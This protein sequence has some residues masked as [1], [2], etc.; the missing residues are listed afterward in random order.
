MKNWYYFLVLLFFSSFALHG[1]NVY[2]H[3]SELKGMED[4]NGNTN[5]LYRINSIQKNTNSEIDSNSIYLFNTTNKTDSLFQLDYGWSD[6]FFDG[7][8]RNVIGF[9]FW[10][11]DPRK[12]IVCGVDG[13]SEPNPIVDRFDKMNLFKLG[14]G[15]INFIGISRQNDSLVYCTFWNN[16]LFKS[17]TG[18]MTWNTV[19]NFNAISLSP[20]NDKILFTSGGNKLIKT[21]DGGL[22]QSIVDSIPLDIYRQDQLF[23]DKDTNYIYSA[24]TYYLDHRVYKLLVSHNSGNAPWQEKFTSTLP[25][26]LSVDNSTAGSVYLATGKN[27]YQ[28]TDFGNTFNLF[29]SFDRK[30]VGI[31]K[32]PESSKL[33]AATYNTIYEIDGATVNI[34]KQIP[35]D[36]E[37]FKFDPLDIGNKWVYKGS[38]WVPEEQHN[39]VQSAE[40]I[41]DTVMENQQIFKQIRT[42]GCDA[43]SGNFVLVFHMK[44][45]IR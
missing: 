31:Y 9:D 17:T 34:I 44:E 12:F 16:Q 43:P 41:K 21:T 4:Y 19:S 24:V 30:L 36:K 28:S 3:F 22:T 18:G 37:I 14:M 35:I 27:I 2:Q 39:F 33:Y 42:I 23:Y 25:I 7:Y 20:Y 5:L 1:Q 40:I 8:S 45:L 15:G 29:K 26:Y 6:I 11:R 32:K 13:Y 10:E 38:F